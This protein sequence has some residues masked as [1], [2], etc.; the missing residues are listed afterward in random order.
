MAGMCLV[1][2]FNLFWGYLTMFS[3]IITIISIALVAALALATLYYGGSSW[4]RGNAA[5]SAATLTNQGEQIRGALALYYTHKGEYPATLDDLVTA[6]YL[7]TVPVPPAMSAALEPSVLASAF[8]AGEAWEALA[9]KHPAFMVKDTVSKEVCQELNYQAR[10]SDAIYDKI[11][12]KTAMQCF[13]GAEGPF[14]YV[15]GVPGSEGASIETAVGKYNSD[16]GAD[17]QVK[18]PLDES[19]IS[20]P[21]TKNKGTGNAQAPGGS[22]D[23]GENPEP[24][25]I[26]MFLQGRVLRDADSYFAVVAQCT[27]QYGATLLQGESLLE[28]PVLPTTSFYSGGVGAPQDPIDHAYMDLGSVQNSLYPYSFESTDLTLTVCIPVT[29]ADLAALPYGGGTD[30]NTREVPTSQVSFGFSNVGPVLVG[31]TPV[32]FEQ[33]LVKTTNVTLNVNGTVWNAGA[34]VYLLDQLNE[35]G[36]ERVRHGSGDLMYLTRGTQPRTSITVRY[37]DPTSGVPITGTMALSGGDAWAN[38]PEMPEHP[39]RSGEDPTPA[40]STGDASGVI[41]FAEVGYADAGVESYFSFKLVLLQNGPIAIESVTTAQGWSVEGSCVGTTLSQPYDKGCWTDIYT[42]ASLTAGVHAVPVTVALADGRSMTKTIFVRAIARSLLESDSEWPTLE[43]GLLDTSPF[44]LGALT[45]VGTRSVTITDFWFANQNGLS[46]AAGG[47][48]V[49]TILAA[50]ATCDVM[51]ASDGTSVAEPSEA[52]TGNL[53]FRVTTDDGITLEDYFGV[54]VTLPK[55][56]VTVSGAT[57]LPFMPPAESLYDHTYTVTNGGAYAT[58][59]LL[60]NPYYNPRTA[61]VV[62]TSVNQPYMVVP[63]NG[64][65]AVTQALPMGTAQY[66]TSGGIVGTFEAK[67]ADGTRAAGEKLVRLP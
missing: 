42:P 51:A 13:G 32:D 30:P 28:P 18:S 65:C 43:E 62:N 59:I 66:M 19:D 7:K 24:P 58:R 27:P 48:S 4:T 20:V 11:D 5:A 17:W 22:D 6:E 3:L 15:V 54:D 34:Y 26:G 39:N 9:P 10:G 53:D 38:A 33:R 50:G 8:A 61:C 16:N 35:E 2:A 1:R 31:G 36:S 46:L 55:P 14:T 29:K 52:W 40:P 23:E 47:C 45:N 49:G 41:D 25:V 56:P 12:G 63:A 44:K 37:S 60:P 64:S 21:E 67:Y 57:V